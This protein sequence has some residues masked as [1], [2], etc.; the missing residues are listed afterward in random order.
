MGYKNIE[1]FLTSKC[2][3]Q[4]PFCYVKPGSIPD[5]ECEK[6]YE[7]VDLIK[8][9]YNRYGIRI[10]GGEP[11]LKKDLVLLLCNSFSNDE[12]CDKISITTNG[13]LLDDVFLDILNLYSKKLEITISLHNYD[14]VKYNCYNYFNLNKKNNYNGKLN[15]SY[16]IS[17][18]NISR[19][20]DDYFNIINNYNIVP[21]LFIMKNPPYERCFNWGDLDLQQF[22]I[23]FSDFL[24]KIEYYFDIGENYIPSLVRDYLSLLL[25]FKY[26]GYVSKVSC[27]DNE[28]LL[29]FSN[30]KISKCYF[31]H[32]DDF[33]NT[34]N[35]EILRSFNNFKCNSCDLKLLC[36]NMCDFEDRNI[37]CFLQKS[38]FK[39]LILFN[40]SLKNNKRYIKWMMNL[41]KMR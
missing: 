22:D 18:L 14:D 6:L 38:I 2:N 40:N 33:D 31:T 9:K 10:I 20:S 37:V 1:F 23:Y 29:S 19:F 5:M 34:S 12:K 11:L 36:F 25:E 24:K 4:C 3:L 7:Y 32:I 17:P 39:N 35:S 41:I 30:N 16:I 26:N 21:L 28:T 13:I 15:F 8:K 27:F